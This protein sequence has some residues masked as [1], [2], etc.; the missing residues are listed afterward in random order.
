M[1]LRPLQLISLTERR[2]YRPPSPRSSRIILGGLTCLPFLF[3]LMLS[4][5]LFGQAASKVVEIAC[6][7][8][9][10]QQESGI[11]WSSRMIKRNDGHT[12][13]YRR[14]E[15]S[16]G[17]VQKLVSIDG[18]EPSGPEKVKND[19]ILHALRT[20]PSARKKQ[21]DAAHLDETRMRSM[22]HI[23][24]QMFRFSDKS[25][26]G[27]TRVIAFVPNPDFN[28]ATFEERA[29]HSLA[30][31]IRLQAKTFRIEGLDATVSDKV[32]FGYGILGS[33]TKGGT[34]HLRLA[35]VDK[36]IWKTQTA[37]LDVAGHIAM[38]KS[39]NKNEDDDRSDM[40]R[41]PRGCTILCALDILNVPR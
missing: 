37:K 25:Y 8:E 31:E 32:N 5:P 35:E 23:V 38:V 30:G 13:E 7:D 26:D 39:L 17:T 20:D 6:E 36:G 21:E 29:L 9:I 41:L 10:K 40:T 27:D 18:H 11:L 33:L 3:S 28:P 1:S 19:G 16:G 24:P 22:L 14:L 12:F 4:A 34:I 15:T 2:H